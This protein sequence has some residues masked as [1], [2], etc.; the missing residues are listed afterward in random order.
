MR[1]EVIHKERTIPSDLKAGDILQS[2]NNSTVLIAKDV[3]SG[4]LTVVWLSV[5]GSITAPHVQCGVKDIQ[6]ELYVEKWQRIPG[7]TLR[8]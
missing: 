6:K 4:E 7:V 5:A 3:V 8:T 2:I 1:V